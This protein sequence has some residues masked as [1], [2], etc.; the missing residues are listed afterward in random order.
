M[1]AALEGGRDRLNNDNLSW[2]ALLGRVQP[3]VNMERV[4]ADVGVIAARIDQL[5]PGRSTSLVVHAATFFDSPEEREFILPFASVILAGFALVLLI[6]CAN[7]A[8]LL[9]ARASVRQKEI[10]LRLS[11]GAGRG[12]LVRQ[13]LTESILL[14]LIGG[15]LGSMLA[16]QCFAGV[17]RLVV[18]H[19][20]NIVSKLRVNVAPDVHVLTYALALTVVTGIAFGLMPAWQSSRLDLN[21]ALKEDGAYA[22]SGKKGGWLRNVLVGTQIAVSMILLLAAGLLLRGLYHAQTIDPGF[23]IKNVASMFLNLEVQGYDASRATF[24]MQ[25]LRERVEALPGVAEVA[26][27]E[28]AP[29]SADHSGGS[30]S[31]PGKTEKIGIEYN[32]VSQEYFPLL[33]IPIVRG[34]SFERDEVSETSASV[35]ITESTARRLWPGQDPLAKTLRDAAGHEYAVIGVSQDAQVS[36]SRPVEHP[37]HLFPSR[38]ANQP[39]GVCAGPIC[40]KL[41]RGW[42]R[43]SQRG[44][45]A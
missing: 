21:A 31:L 43:H 33:G 14:S 30:F 13:L 7:V 37:V 36:S 4:R 1:Q 2:L 27:A 44:V 3:G 41:C 9:L 25:R 10:A 35:I 34:R 11:I 23:E 40:R 32:H 38:K 18:S 39:A 15:A 12:R 24:F 42:Q 17:I 22:G 45:I 28:C 16:F 6:A 26:L 19:L 5:H 29:L 8:N 20:P